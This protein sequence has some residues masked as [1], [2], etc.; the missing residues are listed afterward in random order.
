MHEGTST[1]TIMLY[2]GQCLTNTVRYREVSLFECI[3]H[4]LPGISSVNLKVSISDYFF[5]VIDYPKRKEA[6]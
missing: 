1:C 6:N 4:V 2:G 3:I 5:F